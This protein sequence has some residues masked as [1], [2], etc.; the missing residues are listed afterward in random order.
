ML[1]PWRMDDIGGES[2][3][4]GAQVVVRRISGPCTIRLRHADKISDDHSI[5]SIL[6]RPR[7]GPRDDRP[8]RLY[9]T[10]C[11][12]HISSRSQS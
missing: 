1:R 6:A 8:H 2:C 12:L 3:D 5:L 9:S 7:R 10:Q 4:G 11:S